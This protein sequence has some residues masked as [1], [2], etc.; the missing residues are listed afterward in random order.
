MLRSR[1]EQRGTIT[2]ILDAARAG[3]GGGLLLQGEPGI[4]KSALLADAREQAGDMCVLQATCVESEANLAYATLHQ[5]LRPV[6]HRVRALPAP[7]RQALAVVLGLDLGGP[8]DRFLI[9]LAVLTLLS[10]LASQQPTLCIVDDAQWSDEPSLEIIRFVLRRLNAEPIAALAAVRVG[11]RRDLLAAGMTSLDLSRLERDDAIAVL[12]AHWGDALAPLV[13]HAL[14]AASGGNPLALIELPRSLTVDQR[15]GL[16]PLPEPLPL[17]GQLEDVFVGAIDRLE[18][19]LRTVAMICAVAGRAS[20]ATIDSAAASLG[21][22]TKLLELPGLE[23]VLC[24]DNQ[25]VDFAHPLMRSAAYQQA[26]L[27]A[28]RAAHLA[29]ADVLDGAVDQGDRRAWHRAAAALGPDEEIASELERAADRTLQRSGYAAAAGALERAA[30]L[31]PSVS[32]RVRRVVAAA[33]AAWHSGDPVRAQ[34]L[35]QRAEPLDRQGASV[36]L[37]ARYVQ[38]SIEL[39]SGV[40]ADGL[41]ILLDAVGASGAADPGLATRV[42][43]VAGEASFQAGESASSV[44]E[45]LSA[46][47]ET[48]DPGQR[49]LASGYRAIEPTAT[50]HDL[51]S[52]HDALSAADQPTDPDVLARVAGLAFAVG[53]FATARRLWT[54]VA[55]RARALGAAGSLASALRPVALD[56]TNRGRYA[57]A[58]SLA[59]EGRALAL[60]TGQPNLAWQHASLLA[61]LAGIR[62]REEEARE[63]ADEV[64]REAS[65]RGLHGTVALVRRA[66]GQLCLAVGRPEEAIGHLEAL[67]RLNASSHRAI[68]LGVIPD[69]VEAAVRAG[70]TEL[71]ELW[72]R[73]LLRID[74]G[75]FPEARALV[76]RSRALLGSGSDADQD[77]RQALRMHT[78]IDRPLDQAR[79]ALLFGEYLRRERRRVEAREPLRT[80]LETFDRLG[81]VLWAERAR[82]ELRATGETARKREPSTLE[83][84]TRQELQVLRAVGQG[85]TNREVAAQLFISP[86]TVDHHLRSIFQKLGISSRSELIRMALAGEQLGPT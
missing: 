80:A 25:V 44:G 31:S 70:R 65:A 34:S 6:Q 77:F 13:R 2:R 67:W 66:L 85:G 7:Q 14:V 69:L 61:E 28:R 12:D 76:L 73:R 23:Q 82:S 78:A 32:D 8:P 64:I 84:L 9:S 47:P 72:L 53:D 42:L 86:R 4:G 37:R 11:E 10:E 52:F 51:A 21:V 18:P 39:R 43:A 16:A 17:A 49:L 15:A 24:I 5:L 71:A 75:T 62:G 3:N 29:L 57:W 74:E 30:E 36:R 50:H 38:G 27:D 19:E 60:E 59:A 48:N 40:P 26:S 68:A 79:T 33:E 1:D 41:T 20:L 54:G 63:L 81:A 58:E 45:L 22:R 55:S 83:Q 35:V 56:E 46:L